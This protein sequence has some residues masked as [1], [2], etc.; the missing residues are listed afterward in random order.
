MKHT[1]SHADVSQEELE[2]RIRESDY[3]LNDVT[4]ATRTE[5]EPLRFTPRHGTLGG[6]RPDRSQEVSPCPNRRRCR[7]PIRR[8]RLTVPNLV[9]D[10]AVTRRQRRA[11]SG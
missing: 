9:A 2:P 7:A 11:A 6:S 1:L 8:R 3:A 5:C 10:L 4:R